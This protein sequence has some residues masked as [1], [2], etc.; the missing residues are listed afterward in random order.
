MVIG[1]LGVANH[2][3]K[4]HGYNHK[5]VS[6]EILNYKEDVYCLQ[7]KKHH[8]FALAA[9]VFVH[10]CGMRAQKLNIPIDRFENLPKLR[11]S[12]ERSVPVGFNQHK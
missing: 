11:A 5:V 3:R 2:K 8:N 4:I 7:V 12:I 1:G 6:V 10:N 9:G